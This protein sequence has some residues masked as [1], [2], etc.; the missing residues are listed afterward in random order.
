M[1]EDAGFAE[2][3]ADLYCNA[4]AVCR[5]DVGKAVV[6]SAAAACHN[7][8]KPVLLIPGRSRVTSAALVL[9]ECR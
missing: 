6:F 9:F 1:F 4:K 5:R 8:A 2:H 7:G 3:A